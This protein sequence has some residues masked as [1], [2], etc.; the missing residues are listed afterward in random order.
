MSPERGDTLTVSV[1][2]DRINFSGVIRQRRKARRITDPV[3]ALPG[4]STDPG[5]PLV[6]TEQVIALIADF[7]SAA[8]GRQIE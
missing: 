3:S 5:S 4:L 7:P 8:A 2:R 6:I 1:E